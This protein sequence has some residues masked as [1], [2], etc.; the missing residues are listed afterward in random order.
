MI[1]RI[2]ILLICIYL[3]SN[4]NKFKK[5]IINFDK[6]KRK[7]SFNF[8]YRKDKNSYNQRFFCLIFC[9]KFLSFY[10]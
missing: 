6:H 1:Y 7:F 4:I 10:R 5:I 3:K 8:P 9:G 2:I